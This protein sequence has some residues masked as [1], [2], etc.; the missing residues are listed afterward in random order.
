MANTEHLS[1]LKQG[2]EAW[3]RWRSRS[4]RLVPDLYDADLRG[5]DL[6]GIN[7]RRAGLSKTSLSLCNLD[8]A[9]LRE[10]DL[11]EADLFRTQLHRAQLDRAY[12]CRANF[13]RA[14]LSN[15]S[16]HQSLLGRADLTKANLTRAD[17]SQTSLSEANLSQANCTDAIL[18]DTFLKSVRVQGT[19]FDNADLTGV[20]IQ[21]W[22]A[23]DRT[24][25]DSVICKYFFGKYDMW[26]HQFFERHPAEPD[27]YL[28]PGA[29]A[30]A[31]RTTAQAM[32]LVFSEA[33]AWNALR[34]TL[35]MLR[36]R[37]SL[38]LD[39]L[40]RGGENH[41]ILR[42]SVSGRAD[43]AELSQ[44]FWTEYDR[45]RD[46]SAT[47]NATAAADLWAVLDRLANPDAEA[48]S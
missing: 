34:Q 48:T 16:L 18:R 15:A 37:L 35:E 8:R 30:A 29:F 43:V 7:L 11:Y 33:I 47:P 28:A 10:A 39:G 42:L 44:Q 38:Q 20:C 6:R 22:H 26:K 40:T 41:L 14:D 5:Y 45:L 27:D 2:V 1:I 24:R 3:N 25:L 31:L 19:V 17:L 36:D 12:L 32:E 23:D 21:D 46:G 9:D 13:Y 4:R